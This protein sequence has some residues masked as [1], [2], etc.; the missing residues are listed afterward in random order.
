MNKKLEL[1]AFLSL[2]GCLLILTLSL[3]ILSGT[4]AIIGSVIAVMLG[5]L[6][7]GLYGLSVDRK[8]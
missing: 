1:L 5:I 7:G 6:T 4:W 3:T 8:E 2:I